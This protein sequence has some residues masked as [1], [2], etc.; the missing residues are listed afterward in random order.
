M[1][2]DIPDLSCATKVGLRI[3]GRKEDHITYLEVSKSTQNV[4]GMREEK[5]G[6]LP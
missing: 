2:S 3:H 4:L 5:H 6:H 1:F